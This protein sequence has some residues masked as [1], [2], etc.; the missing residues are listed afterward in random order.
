VVRTSAPKEGVTIEIAKFETPLD[1]DYL[2]Y[3]YGPDEAPGFCP[4]RA[5]PLHA[6]EWYYPLEEQMTYDGACYVVRTS[7][8]K[9]VDSEPLVRWEDARTGA[10]LCFRMREALASELG[11]QS[12]APDSPGLPG[13]PGNDHGE[14][15]PRH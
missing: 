1:L 10:K 6:F 11:R 8:T 15:R 5:I 2:L 9:K 4:P 3:V 14:H 13:K 7:M 12:A